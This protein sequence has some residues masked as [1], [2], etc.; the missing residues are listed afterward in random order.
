MK[1]VAQACIVI[2]LVLAVAVAIPA[3]WMPTV[4]DVTLSESG[5][6]VTYNES[7]AT[8]IVESLSSDSSSPRRPGDEASD[9]EEDSPAATPRTTE[10]SRSEDTENL[11][12]SRIN[13]IRTEEGL[14]ELGRSKELDEV[15]QH[16]SDDMAEKG[17]FSHTSPTGETLRE[18]YRK[19]GIGCAGGENIFRYKSTY[20][21]SP[22]VV[23]EVAVEG[24][25]ES[26][27]HRENILR[28][29]FNIEGIGV[30]YSGSEVYVTQNFC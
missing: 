5:V 18:R 28:P 29:Q 17:Y 13:Q 16:H 11:I 23:A 1:R 4:L 24:W 7:A 15:A 19:H 30:T 26:P 21:A 20:G 27:G 8:E 22:A 14:P 9:A 25:M 6:E 10:S 3:S 12:H 2:G